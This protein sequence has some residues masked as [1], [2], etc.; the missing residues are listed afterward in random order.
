MIVQI[1]VQICAKFLIS[2]LK[3][4]GAMAVSLVAMATAAL[5]LFLDILF[6]ALRNQFGLHIFLVLLSTVSVYYVC[7]EM[8]NKIIVL[9]LLP[10]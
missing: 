10:W 4:R 8:D 2:R 5:Y 1:M 7:F 9:L 6:G 3:I